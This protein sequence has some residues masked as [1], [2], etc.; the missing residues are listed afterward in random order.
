MH[1]VVERQ[2]DASMDIVNDG[3]M[4]KPS[5]ATLRQGPARRLGGE[6]VERYYPVVTVHLGGRPAGA[7]PLE[8]LGIDA[9]GEFLSLLAWVTVLPGAEP[10]AN[11]SLTVTPTTVARPDDPGRSAHVQAGR[12][13]PSVS[14]LYADFPRTLDRVVADESGWSGCPCRSL[15]LRPGRYPF[16]AI[17]LTPDRGGMTLT[18]WLDVV[19]AVAA[20]TPPGPD[21]GTTLPLTGGGSVGLAVLGMVLVAGGWLVT[22]VAVRLRP[23]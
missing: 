14:R 18:V 17:G 4:S 20:S 10:T 7:L 16:Y 15:Q 6:A 8:C 2:V 12:E 22:T 9:H 23:R 13:R 5:Y 1:E 3:E 11:D 21:P 19:P